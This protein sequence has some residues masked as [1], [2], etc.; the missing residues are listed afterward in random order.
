M[1]LGRCPICRTHLHLDALISDDA[2]RELLGAISKLDKRLGQAVVSYISL[3]RPEKSDLSNARAHKL[4]TETLD[5]HK[6]PACLAKAL[7]DTVQSLHAKRQQQLSYNQVPKPLANHNYLKQVLNTI[8]GEFTASSTPVKQGSSIEI[9]EFGGAVTDAENDA[10]RDALFK[11]FNA[12]V[13]VK[14]NA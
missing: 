5:L 6:N 13:G 3:F 9:K 11:K 12:K 8:Q 4:M 14:T 10:K 2:G 7:N 1:K